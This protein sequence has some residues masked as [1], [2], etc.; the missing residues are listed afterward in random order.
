MEN[1]ILGG[2]GVPGCQLV[3][4]W[5]AE[6]MSYQG[7]LCILSIPLASEWVPVNARPMM[8]TQQ[9]LRNLALGDAFFLRVAAVSSAGAGPPATLDQPIRI[10]ATI[11]KHHPLSF[12]LCPRAQVYERRKQHLASPTLTCP[13]HLAIAKTSRG[14]RGFL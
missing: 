4:A 12:P 7:P 5:I 8:V 1:P 11:G 10:Q 2:Q 13:H 3:H 9:T 6:R 14:Q